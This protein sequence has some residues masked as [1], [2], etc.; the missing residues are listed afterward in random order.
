MTLRFADKHHHI[1]PQFSTPWR[2]VHNDTPGREGQGGGAPAASP[3]AAAAAS[4]NDDL[5]AQ[6]AAARAEGATKAR[7]EEQAKLRK[8]IEKEEKERKELQAER[9]AQKAELDKLKAAEKE[10]ERAGMKPDERVQAQLR[11]LEEEVRVAKAAAQTAK[12]EGAARF[13]AAELVAYRE[14]VLRQY[15]DQIISQMVV[16]GPNETVIDESAKQAHEFWK[17]NIGAVKA[18]YEAQIAQLQGQQPAAQ[19][20]A[21]PPGVPAPPAN[22]ALPAQPDLSQGFP[23]ATNPQQVVETQGPDLSQLTSEQAVRSGAYSGEVRAQILANLAGQQNPGMPLGSLPRH[24]VPSQPQTVNMP[25]GVEQPQG[26]PT[27]PA[28]PQGQPQVQPHTPPGQQPGALAQNP[29][30][31]PPANDPATLARQAVERTHAGQNPTIAATPGAQTALSQAQAT[32]QNPQA[33][34]NERFQN[35]PPIQ[36]GQQ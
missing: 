4:Q 19:P 30:A 28:A 12:D 16:A 11:D 22:P 2:T 26:H 31:A 20:G 23:T 6:L 15:G 24:M 10:R 9:D 32:G 14:R 7:E 29:A 36:P 35:T 8:K 1:G 33:A 3:A 21:Q 17:T 27:G 34:F 25:G 5:E 18:H 13:R